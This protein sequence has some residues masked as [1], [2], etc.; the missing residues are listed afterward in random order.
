MRN[1]MVIGACIVALLGG[2]AYAVDSEQACMDQL[3]KAEAAVD[4][5]VEAK[6]LSEGDVEDANLYLD[7]T[8]AACTEGN[9]KKA[10]E[11]LANVNKM[12]APPAE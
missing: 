10:T 9:F 5:Q 11:N 4:Q 3:A 2:T 6:A 8:D 7:E 12:L 1:L